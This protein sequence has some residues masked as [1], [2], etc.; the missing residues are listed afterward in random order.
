[1]IHG[2]SEPRDQVFEGQPATAGCLE[3][4]RSVC[5]GRAYWDTGVCVSAK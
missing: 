3:G 1:M 2:G 4:G 5:G